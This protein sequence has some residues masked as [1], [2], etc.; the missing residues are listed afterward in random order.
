MFLEIRL[1]GNFE[2]ICGNVPLFVFLLVVPS[3][4]FN[5]PLFEAEDILLGPVGFLVGTPAKAPD[6][7]RAAALGDPL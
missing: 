2:G 4:L 5:S 6:N 7:D 3:S 1:I